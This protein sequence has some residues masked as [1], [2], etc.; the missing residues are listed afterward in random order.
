[1]TH[2]THSHIS[3]IQPLNF[4]IYESDSQVR[5]VNISHTT[6]DQTTYIILTKFYNHAWV[7]YWILCTIRTTKGTQKERL[8]FTNYF[9]VHWRKIHVAKGICSPGIYTYTYEQTWTSGERHQDHLQLFHLWQ[10][11]HRGF[12]QTFYLKLK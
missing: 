3:N 12:G 11:S 5:Q 7:G 8:P 10:L 1:V 9:N 4:L 2:V 6:T